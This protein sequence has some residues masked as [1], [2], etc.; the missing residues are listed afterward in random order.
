MCTGGCRR[1]VDRGQRPHLSSLSG[2][3]AAAAPSAE[4]ADTDTDAGADTDVVAGAADGAA[5]WCLV[6]SWAAAAVFWATVLLFFSSTCCWCFYDTCCSKY[7]SASLKHTKYQHM[8]PYSVF[9]MRTSIVGTAQVYFRLSLR[10]RL[11]FRK[12][13]PHDN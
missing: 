9:S 5:D 2:P 8:S 3:A 7:S 13:H 12:F 6:A 1:H 10:M 4:G 11:C